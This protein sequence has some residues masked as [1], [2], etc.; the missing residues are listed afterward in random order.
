MRISHVL[1][2]APALIGAALG[3]YAYFGPDTGVTGT[4]GALLALI[5]AVAVTLAGFAAM[6]SS[7]HGGFLGFLNVLI[8]LGAALT[9]VAA[10]FLMQYA[11]A[12]AMALAFLG[13]LVAAFA[14]SRR[15]PAR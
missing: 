9:A 4:G 7:V 3:A 1:V 13:L 2:I 11:F 5:G 10:W 15:S 8:G 6:A 12:V 14:T